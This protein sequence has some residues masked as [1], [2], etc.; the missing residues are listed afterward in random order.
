MYVSF[1]VCNHKLSKYVV[2]YAVTAGRTE[3]DS[4]RNGP[5]L[6]AFLCVFYLSISVSDLILIFCSV[7]KYL[8]LTLIIENA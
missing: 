2:I 6:V 7:F 1:N 4:G 3:R 5:C 8:I